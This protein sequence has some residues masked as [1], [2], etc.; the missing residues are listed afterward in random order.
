MIIRIL[1]VLI[2]LCPL[3]LKA[4]P[5]NLLEQEVGIVFEPKPY[6]PLLDDGRILEPINLHVPNNGPTSNY[7]DQYS[8]ML[9]PFSLEILVIS[10][11]RVYLDLDTCSSKKEEILALISKQYLDIEFN[12]SKKRYERSASKAFINVNCLQEHPSPFFILEFVHRSEVTDKKL[13]S[14]WERYFAKS[15]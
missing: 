6:K 13:R 4:N 12:S 11:R 5:R 15:S 14:L 9:N 3:V 8:L 2:I 7:F 10:A 1:I